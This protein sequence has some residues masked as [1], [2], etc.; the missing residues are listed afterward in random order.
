MAS[1]RAQ[2]AAGD[3]LR[4][5]IGD[6]VLIERGLGQ[7]PV[8]L[9]EVTEPKSIGAKGFVANARL[10]HEN[11]PKRTGAGRAGNQRYRW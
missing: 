7:I 8:D 6:G 11:L 1:F 5:V 3:D 10:L 4:F 9:L 2:R